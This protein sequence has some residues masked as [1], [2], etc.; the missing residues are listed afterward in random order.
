[1][2]MNIDG[3]SIIYDVPSVPGGTINGGYRCACGAW[4]TNGWDHRCLPQA[5]N[6]GYQCSYCGMWVFTGYHTCGSQ[7]PALSACQHCFCIDVPPSGER[8]RPHARCCKC[9]DVRLK[10][11]A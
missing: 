3:T 1:M 11:T 6:I 10:E 9:A 7:S 5:F 2:A 8:T 4:V